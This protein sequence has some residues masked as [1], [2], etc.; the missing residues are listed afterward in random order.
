LKTGI[1]ANYQEWEA[2]YAKTMVATEVSSE[3]VVRNAVTMVS[4]ALL[5]VAVIRV[6][7][8]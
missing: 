4:T 8:L 5:P 7:V 1:S 2:V 3:V 6:P